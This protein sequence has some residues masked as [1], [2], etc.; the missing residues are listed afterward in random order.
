MCVYIYIHLLYIFSGKRVFKFF[1]FHVFFSSKTHLLQSKDC[2]EHGN[3]NEQKAFK[4]LEAY[5]MS[6]SHMDYESP[7]KVQHF[8]C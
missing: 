4:Y 5:R 8:G 7:A 2:R 1:Y 6:L 3:V